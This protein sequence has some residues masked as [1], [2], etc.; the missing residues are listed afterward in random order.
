[1]RD[2]SC[3]S[4]GRGESEKQEN[5]VKMGFTSRNVKRSRYALFSFWMKEKET[6]LKLINSIFVK[7]R[8]QGVL[9]IDF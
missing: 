9:Y 3:R 6:I 1:M 7:G 5:L 2:R 4:F 8:C